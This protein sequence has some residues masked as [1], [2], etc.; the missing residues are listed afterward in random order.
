VCVCVCVSE[1]VFVCQRCVCVSEIECV[2][3]RESPRLLRQALA[4]VFVISCHSC[5]LSFNLKLVT[6]NL[7]VPPGVYGTC[8][9]H[10]PSCSPSTRA[11]VAIAYSSTRGHYIRLPAIHHVK[12]GENPKPCWLAHRAQPTYLGALPGLLGRRASPKR[13]G[14]WRVA[15]VR[16]GCSL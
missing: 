15:P 11:L 1:R 3:Q 8:V 13:R 7:R 12:N 4:N 9:W 16:R 6:L 10:M 14:G 5:N 2:C